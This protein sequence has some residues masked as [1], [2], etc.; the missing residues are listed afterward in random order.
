[1]MIIIMI[2]IIEDDGAKEATEA[3][4]II[5]QHILLSWRNFKAIRF[6]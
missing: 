6:G 3:N 1:M 2:I 4:Y 5:I